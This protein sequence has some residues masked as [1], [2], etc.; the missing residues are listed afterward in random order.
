MALALKNCHKKL[1]E[2]NKLSGNNVIIVAFKKT[3][4]DSF[5]LVISIPS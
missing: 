4:K 2:Q 1:C 5:Y 3:M